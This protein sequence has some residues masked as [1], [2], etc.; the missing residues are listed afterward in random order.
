[1][2]LISDYSH[3]LQFKVN[4]MVECQ[5]Q[6]KLGFQSTQNKVIT[7]NRVQDRT[8]FSHFGSLDM[9]IGD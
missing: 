7:L 6:Y 4:K 3:L 8:Y 1:M 2:Y 5:Y 9:V